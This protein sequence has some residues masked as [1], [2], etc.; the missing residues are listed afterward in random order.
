M[1]T[2]GGSGIVFAVVSLSGDEKE[3]VGIKFPGR[4]ALKAPFKS[5]DFFLGRMDSELL[6]GGGQTLVSFVLE[7]R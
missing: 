4:T 3:L 1:D 5:R 6:V 7:K 2:T